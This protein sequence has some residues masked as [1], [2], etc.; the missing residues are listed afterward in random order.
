MTIRSEG[1]HRARSPALGQ[2]PRPVPPG[3]DQAAPG[4]R[5]GLGGRRS[6]WSSKGW[7][8]SRIRVGPRARKI[9][10]SHSSSIMARK[11]GYSWAADL[12]RHTTTGAEG[13]VQAPGQLVDPGEP[14]L[15]AVPGRDQLL[16][17]RQQEQPEQLVNHRA[18]RRSRKSR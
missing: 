5:V 12:R 11:I 4:R 18:A 10:A 15:A 3:P 6:K 7:I 1:V 8:S 9:G 17:D 14:R 2:H 13:S 16:E